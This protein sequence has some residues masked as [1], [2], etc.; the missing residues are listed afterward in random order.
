MGSSS[1]RRHK[2]PNM[3]NRRI[4][5]V[6]VARDKSKT[7]RRSGTKALEKGEHFSNNLHPKANLPNNK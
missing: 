4:R 7:C 5:V 3:K 2:T 6:A 1:Q